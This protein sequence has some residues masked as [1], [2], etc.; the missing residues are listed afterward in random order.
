MMPRKARKRQP[1]EP[2]LATF[3][4]S[5]EKWLDFQKAAKAGGTTASA[6]IVAFIDSYLA[7]EQ[8]FEIEQTEPELETQPEAELSGNLDA[9][10]EKVVESKIASFDEFLNHIHQSFRELD[11]RIEKVTSIENVVESKL[12]TLEQML[13]HLHK[14]VQ[15]I[16]E[17]LGKVENAARQVKSETYNVPKLIDIE[18]V[19]LDNSNIDINTDQARDE[20]LNNLTGLTEKALCDEF[21]LNPSSIVRNAKMRGLSSPDYLNQITGWV[22]V[23]GKYYPP[24][25]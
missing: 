9:I 5:H 21:G 20:Q 10:I 18:A 1:D 4:I 7:G 11:E 3:M 14:S 15:Q 24:E 25:Q 19:T 2:V 12:A 8:S 17:R 23:K 16:D 22:Y 13:N 6:T